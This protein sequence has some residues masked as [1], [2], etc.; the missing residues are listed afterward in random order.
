MRKYERKIVLEDTTMKIVA[1]RSMSGLSMRKVSKSSGVN[2]SMI[3]R[4]FESKEKLLRACYD[5][6]NDYF[7]DELKAGI[8]KKIE[9]EGDFLESAEELWYEFTEM[10]IDSDYKTL[11]Y[12]EYRDMHK[13]YIGIED[14]GR[15]SES[16][17][18]YSATPE[19]GESEELNL[20]RLKAQEYAFQFF[21]ESATAYA[22]K[23]IR[24][25]IKDTDENRKLTWLL[26]CRGFAH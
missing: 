16:T 18:G 26:L 14:V 7:T 15:V 9:S 20:G 13:M 5:S 12:C 4:D 2:E 24:K 25:E 17:A 22:K 6:V 19:E 8:E 10:L 1:E 23:V 11:Y 3:Y 21:I